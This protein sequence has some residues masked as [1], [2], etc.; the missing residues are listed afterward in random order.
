MSD[1][2]T[3]AVGGIEATS[4]DKIDASERE[5]DALRH[6][7]EGSRRCEEGLVTMDVPGIPAML[8]DELV[9]SSTSTAV[10]KLSPKHGVT[11]S[12]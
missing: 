7:T 2:T 11:E 5:P 4:R 10:F 3:V 6:A 12:P 8:M 1:G 9:I